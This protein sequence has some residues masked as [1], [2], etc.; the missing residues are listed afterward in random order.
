MEVELHREAE[1]YLDRLPEPANGRI[2]AAIDG[3]EEDPPRGDIRPYAGSPGMFRLKVGDY[4]ILFRFR[5][6]GILVTHI[7]SRGQTYTKKNRG[8][9]R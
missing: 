7:E 5:E 3:L 9:K 6:N 8:N 4:R 1:K 2:S